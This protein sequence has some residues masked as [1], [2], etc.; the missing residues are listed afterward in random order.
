MNNG[1]YYR[2]DKNTESIYLTLETG[3]ELNSYITVFCVDTPI[4]VRPDI[5]KFS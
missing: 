2:N 5:L 4:S 1:L 3:V